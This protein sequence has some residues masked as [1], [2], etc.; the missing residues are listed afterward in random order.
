[1]VTSYESHKNRIRMMATFDLNYMCLAEIMIGR[2][3]SDRSQ[4]H[5]QIP[6]GRLK[7]VHCIQK[8]S[9]D[10]SLNRNLIEA[11][12]KHR[13]HFGPITTGCNPPEVVSERSEV[14]A[15][16]LILASKGSQ[17]GLKGASR[18]MNIKKLSDASHNGILGKVY[19]GM[20][21]FPGECSS[22]PGK[23]I[24]PAGGAIRPVKYLC[25]FYMVLL[26]V[27][28]LVVGFAKFVAGMGRG[29]HRARQ[30]KMSLSLRR[31][32]HVF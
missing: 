4:P 22:C 16:G 28:F 32:A 7:R 30:G 15:I 2:L 25:Q 1:M 20:F 6:I 21:R 11:T 17:R 19:R 29:A 14:V 31:R 18:K 8:R 3:S 23:M 27:D 12:Q 13:N 9:Y 24:F 10:L 26:N 5:F